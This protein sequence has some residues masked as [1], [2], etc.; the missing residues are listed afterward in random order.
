MRNKNLQFIKFS[1]ILA[2]KVGISSPLV[3]EKIKKIINISA[4]IIFSLIAFAVNVN[5]F[6]KQK[7]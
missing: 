3:D 5:K 7:I 4:N 6:L 1:L 2:L